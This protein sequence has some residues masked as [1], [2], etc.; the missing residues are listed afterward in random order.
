MIYFVYDDFGVIL[1]AENTL[2]SI[3]EGEQYVAG[4]QEDYDRWLN[5]NSSVAIMDGIVCHIEYSPPT[6]EVP[7]VE[8]PP[9]DNPPKKTYAEI[10]NGVIISY[11]DYKIKNHV[12]LDINYD[13][14]VANVGNYLKD[15]SG[16]II[17]DESG[18]VVD[19]SV[20]EEFLAE[21]LNEAKFKKVAEN[22][23]KRTVKLNAGVEHKGIIFDSDTDQKIN[24]MFAANAMADDDTITWLGKDNDPLDC[25]KADI[26]AIGQK[27]ADLTYY[28]WVVKNPQFL[29]EI[30][31]AETIAHV[32]NIDI[33]Y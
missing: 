2:E 20:T 16:R 12:E 32:E 28:V 29:S 24:L 17:I 18:M 15:D 10:C 7:Q 3:V 21:R 1:R 4:T 31:S 13:D 9:V 33:D 5:D 25:S 11:C 23:A 30:N 6:P 27:I 14:F 8:V 26:L 22:E 19:I